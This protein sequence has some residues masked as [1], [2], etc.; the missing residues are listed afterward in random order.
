MIVKKGEITYGRPA[1]D[2]ANHFI[3]YSGYTKTNLQILKMTYIA[4]GHSLAILDRPLISDV[5]EAWEHGPVIPK[6]YNKYKKYKSDLIGSISHRPRPF[7]REER[8]ILD[9]VFGLY[10]KYC[11]YYL[12]Q[13]THEN[14]ELETPWKK[15][16]VPGMNMRIPDDIT[17]EYYKVIIS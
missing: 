11:G 10:G 4:H 2:V 6:I 7:D 13:I 8:E 17:K 14:G 15:C 5:V 12:S 9:A 16:Y 1:L 3:E